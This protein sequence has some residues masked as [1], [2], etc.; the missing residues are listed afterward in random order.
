MKQAIYRLVL[1]GVWT[2][3]GIT[4][5]RLGG[6]N[7]FLFPYL[8]FGWW[9]APLGWLCVRQWKSLGLIIAPILTI[10]MCLASILV[11]AS[12]MDRSSNHLL[13]E[14]ITST[15]KGVKLDTYSYYDVE[16]EEVH[17]DFSS[18]YIIEYEDVFIGQHEWIARFQNGSRYYITIPQSCS[19]THQIGASKL[20][21]N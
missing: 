17:R 10:F 16:L 2:G 1:L 8:L 21:D 5:Y 11:H 6:C 19:G 12:Y 4:L 3:V 20:A 14:F 9:L 7:I 13:N 18:A 15:A